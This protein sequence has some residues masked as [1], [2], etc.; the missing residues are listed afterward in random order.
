[1]CV[2]YFPSQKT[3][4]VIL[5]SQKNNND[6]DRIYHKLSDCIV[7]KKDKNYFDKTFLN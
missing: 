4:V 7:L 5:L 1:M 3:M 2:L 6:F